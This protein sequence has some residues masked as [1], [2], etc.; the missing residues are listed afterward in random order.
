M[1]S[2]SVSLFDLVEFSFQ[3]FEDPFY[4]PSIL[5]FF[6]NRATDSLYLT[7]RQKSFRDILLRGEKR[8]FCCD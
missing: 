6:K 4:D 7:K 2:T 1:E 5:F 3:P 8:A